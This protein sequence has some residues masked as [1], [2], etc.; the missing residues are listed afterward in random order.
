MTDNLE[1]RDDLGSPETGVRVIQADQID[2]HVAEG[3]RVWGADFGQRASGRP[4]YQDVGSLSG[5]GRVGGWRGSQ[6]PRLQPPPIE[7]GTRFSRTR[8]SDALHRRLST[9]ARQGR[10]G[11]GA[12]T[13]PLRSINPSRSAEH[14]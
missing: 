13:A 8:L 3:H 11:L 7:P 1:T 4:G 2:P 9:G 5:V 10:F 12:M 6:W 14:L